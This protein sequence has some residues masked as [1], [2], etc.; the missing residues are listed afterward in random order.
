MALVGE[1]EL[2][3]YLKQRKPLR[4]HLLRP[5]HAQLVYIGMRREADLL[6]EEP[7]EVKGADVGDLRQLFDV[8]HGGEIILQ[9]FLHG[10]DVRRF[11]DH[12]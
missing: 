1:A 4:H 12:P 6:L 3:G 10:E 9:I 11:Y 5:V 7:H 8:R 2:V